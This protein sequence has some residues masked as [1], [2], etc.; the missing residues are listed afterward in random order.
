MTPQAPDIRLSDLEGY[1]DVAQILGGRPLYQFSYVHSFLFVERED[2]L[3][4]SWR[5]VDMVL[6]ELEPPR[7]KIGFRFHR[8]ADVAYSGFGQIMGLYV[9]SIAERGW[10]KLRYEVGDYEDGHIHLFCHS[11]TLYAPTNVAS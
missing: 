10:E 2:I 6:A 5:D 7:H 11:V 9:Q 4:D 3:G 8:V 1:A